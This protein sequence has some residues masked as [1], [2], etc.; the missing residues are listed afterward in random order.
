M[1]LNIKDRLIL[2]N[3]Y[4][5]LIALADNDEVKKK[6]SDNLE[7]VQYGF[8][9]EYINLVPEIDKKVLTEREGEEVVNILEMF[10]QIQNSLEDLGAIE[11]EKSKV[12]FSGFDADHE[13]SQLSYADYLIKKRPIYQKFLENI[14]DSHFPM[15]TIYRRM[16]DEWKR[17]DNKYQLTRDDIVRIANSRNIANLIHQFDALEDDSMN[18]EL[19]DKIYRERGRPETDKVEAIS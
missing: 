17:S 8:E 12:T 6:Y 18:E 1:N 10:H 9:S 2:A 14:A 11:I 3:Q 7:I 15:L 16:L 4:T 5:L 19:L 13:S